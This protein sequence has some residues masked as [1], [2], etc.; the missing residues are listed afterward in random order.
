MSLSPRKPKLSSVFIV[1]QYPE[2]ADTDVKLPTH[3]SSPILLAATP[4]P[5]APSILSSRLLRTLE[6][7]KSSGRIKKVNFGSKITEKP[8]RELN[9]PKSAIIGGVVRNDKGYMTMGDFQLQPHDRVVVFTL[10]E[11]I[12]NVEAFFK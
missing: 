2:V 10:P 8:I 11:A 1:S 4:S 7:D 6:I 3:Q 5:I 9:F 12:A